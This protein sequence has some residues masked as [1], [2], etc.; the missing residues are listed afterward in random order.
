MIQYVNQGTL[1]EQYQKTGCGFACTLM[2]LR[3][4]GKEVTPEEVIDRIVSRN[5]YLE[6]VG[7]RHAII[8][9]T[10][11]DYGIPAYNQEFTPPTANEYEMHMRGAEK[12]VK[13]AQINSHFLVIAS[14]NRLAKN[15]DHVGTDR[16]RGGHLVLIHQAV[17]RSTDWKKS[18]LH[19]CDPDYSL[20]HKQRVSDTSLTFEEFVDVWRGLAIFIGA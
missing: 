13:W 14:V 6:G 1:P 8:A 5:G 10:L 4:Y 18:H 16:R 9:R 2:T 11:V 19:L 7:C 17:A 20:P 12:I 15:N 3:H